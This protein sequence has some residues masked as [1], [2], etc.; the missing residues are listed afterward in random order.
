M[1]GVV[2]Q[3]DLGIVKENICEI[4]KLINHYVKLAQY[5]YLSEVSSS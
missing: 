4:N 5:E 2:K 3:T 1:R